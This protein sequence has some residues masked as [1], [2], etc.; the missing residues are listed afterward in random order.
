MRLSWR[1]SLRIF[2]HLGNVLT[3]GESAEG[4]EGA[5]Q[6]HPHPG[7]LPEGA[8]GGAEKLRGVRDCRGAPIAIGALQ[9][10]REDCRCPY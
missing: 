8:G 9:E 3:C 10:E 1:R 7:D 2:H 5:G 6:P 4:E